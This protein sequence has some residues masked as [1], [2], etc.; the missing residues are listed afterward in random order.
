MAGRPELALKDLAHPTVGNQHDAPL[1]RSLAFA[2]LSKWA[3]AREGFRNIEA[4][5]G[6]LPIEM[7]RTMMKEMIRAFLEVGDFTAAVSQMRYA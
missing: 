4:A 3:E 2:R 5:M 6:T 1:W 7:Q